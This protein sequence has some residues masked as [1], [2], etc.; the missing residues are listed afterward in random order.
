[1][2]Q[3]TDRKRMEKKQKHDKNWTKAYVCQKPDRRQLT[4]A[5][6]ELWKF[7][8][9]FVKKQGKLTA[10]S[11]GGQ[12]MKIWTNYA[13]ICCCWDPISTYTNFTPWIS[14]DV[15]ILYQNDSSQGPQ[16]FFGL[17]V[18]CVRDWVDSCGRCLRRKG[19][20]QKH[21][22]SLTNWQFGHFSGR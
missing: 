1:M 3:V 13:S 4:G 18:M 9:D 12:N 21:R 22:N 5:S 8:C 7:W 14:V 11:T 10:F 15:T 16:A 19:R 6:K 17:A 20:P 2:L